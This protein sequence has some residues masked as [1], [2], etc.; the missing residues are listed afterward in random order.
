MP[1]HKQDVF[2]LYLKKKII[3]LIRKKSKLLL[4]IPI[5][6]ISVGVLSCRVVEVE[7]ARKIFALIE[8]IGRLYCCRHKLYISLI[9]LILITKFHI[10]F[11]D[12][13]I[14]KRRISSWK[15]LVIFIA[16]RAIINRHWIH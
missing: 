11:P 16:Y 12:N 4:Y 14:R 8:S 2:P 10:Y 3:F 13:K 15:L 5:Y 6:F 1:L 9:I 7:K